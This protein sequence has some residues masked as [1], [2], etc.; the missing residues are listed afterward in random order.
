MKQGCVVMVSSA[1]I[2]SGD[3]AH[4]NRRQVLS[5]VNGVQLMVMGQPAS[6]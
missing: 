2:S 1:T 3:A 6:Y 5:A 4:F